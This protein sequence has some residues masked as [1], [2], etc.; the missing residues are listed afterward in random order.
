VQLFLFIKTALQQIMEI[1]KNVFDKFPVLQTRRLTLRDIRITDAPQIFGMRSSGRV[2]RFIA[3]QDMDDMQA[4]VALAEK[5]RQAY[6]QGLGI[7]WAGVLTE[8]GAII[9]TCG[10]N[11]IDYPNLRAEIGGEL[12]VDNWGRQLALEAVTAIV[13]FGLETMNLHAIEARLSPG[14]R[15]AIALLNHLGFVKEAHFKD[16][17]YFNGGFSDMAVYTVINPAH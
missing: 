9:G 3:R 4:A 2:N 5:T 10:F 8:D 13:Q 11:R 1:N 14:N 6:E 12:S 17:I 16:Y 7:G 15:G